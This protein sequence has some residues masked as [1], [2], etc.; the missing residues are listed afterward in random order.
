M[1]VKVYRGREVNELVSQIR[2]ECG[3]QALI[4]NTE[5]IDANLLEITVHLP[6]N[7][8]QPAPARA[9]ATGLRERLNGLLSQQGVTAAL[10]GTILDTLAS[11][12]A[13]GSSIEAQ[14][15][16]CFEKIM[17]FDSR[18]PARKRAI[19]F[20]GPTGVGKTTTIAKLAARLQEALDIRVA[21]I[22]ADSYRVGAG[23]QLHTYA[24]L[25]GVACRTIHPKRNPGEEIRSAIENFS[26]ADLVLIDTA[27]CSPRDPQGL[28][29]L[30]N[31]F[32]TL[33]EVERVLVLPAP[34]NEFDL[35]LAS[36]SFS[37][38]GYSRVVLSKLDETGFLGPSLSFASRLGKPLSLFTTGQRV[39]EDIEPAS[40]KRLGWM[41]ARNFH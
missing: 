14:L 6:E 17:K 5:E 21:L 37:P 41:L 34:S 20:F 2:E 22:A 10:R 11:E 30:T 29:R 3:E 15:G 19:A 35:D 18:Y 8:T 32:S 36:R 13:S 33:P 9:E 16:K 26:G 1:N 38:V 27:G 31:D 23:Y 40:A 4:V 24:Q 12:P 7:H 28:S 25:L 39:P